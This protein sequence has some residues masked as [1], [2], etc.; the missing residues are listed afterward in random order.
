MVSS[1]IGLFEIGVSPI[2]VSQTVPPPFIPSYLYEQYFD[3]DDL[4]AFVTTYNQMAQLRTDWFH[5]IR[6]PIYTSPTIAGALLD[7][8][9][10]GLYGIKRPSLPIGVL[11]RVGPLNTW[12]LNTIQL[13]YSYTTGTISYFVANDDIFKRIITWHF[14]KSDGR[15]FTIRWLKRRVLRFLTGRNGVDVLAGDT[16]QVSVVFDTDNQ[17]VITLTIILGSVFTLEDAQIFQAAVHSAAVEL[18]FQFFFSVEIVNDT[19]PTN[20][21]SSGGILVLTD[22]TGYPTSP[23]GLVAGDLWNNGTTVSVV[24]TT[25]PNPFAAPVFFGFVSAA[26]LLVLGGTNLPLTDPVLANQLWNNGGLIAISSG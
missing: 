4:Q 19:G 2:G 17:V 20:L 1:A 6:L 7:W 5:E 3:D 15:F 18:P 8:V 26:Q 10:E 25:T 22:I 12:Q 11:V 14:Y 21:A 24:P 23:S 16:D 13:N 9:A